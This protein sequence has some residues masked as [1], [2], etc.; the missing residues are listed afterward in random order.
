MLVFDPEILHDTHLNLTDKTRVAV[1]LRLNQ[2]RPVFDPDC[3]YAR[4]FWRRASDIEAARFDE[5]LHLKR[6]D[7]LAAATLAAPVDWP[8]RPKVVEAPLA[9]NGRAVLGPSSL[10][11]EGE[12]L[13]VDLSGRR[14]LVFRTNGA[15][16]AVDAS[17][18]HYGVDLSDG[19]FDSGAALLPFLWSVFR[20][21]LRQLGGT[22]P[23]ASV[24]R[25]ERKQWADHT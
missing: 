19:A 14:I 1:W 22:Q 5:V 11:A 16:R 6:E 21:G 7:Y 15:L 3:F 17:C 2:K 9:A 18:P 20:S 8:R 12:R 13:I 25:S 23:D 4:E 24:H 10:V